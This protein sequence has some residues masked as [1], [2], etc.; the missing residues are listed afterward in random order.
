MKNHEMDGHAEYKELVKNT[1]KSESVN[2]NGK[3]QYR[4]RRLR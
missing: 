1:K 4:I 3:R 2:L